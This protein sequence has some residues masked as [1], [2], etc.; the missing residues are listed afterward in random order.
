MNEYSGRHLFAIG[1]GTILLAL[2]LYV[3]PGMNVASYSLLL[4]AV[5]LVAMGISI[6]RT[7]SFMNTYSPPMPESTG[8]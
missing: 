7:L 2:A 4:A 8:R 3:A 1:V 6:A 5:I